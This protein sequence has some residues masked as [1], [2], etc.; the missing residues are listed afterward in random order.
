MKIIKKI[1]T[2]L[3]VSAFSAILTITVFS[4]N[5]NTYNAYISCTK[6]DTQVHKT[7]PFDMKNFYDYGTSLPGDDAYIQAYAS[8]TSNKYH[9]YVTIHYRDY[10]GAGAGTVGGFKTQSEDICGG[11][12][13]L[14][15]YYNQP[16]V[17]FL[18]PTSYAEFSYG[19]ESDFTNGTKTKIV[20]YRL[21]VTYW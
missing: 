19:N 13:N 9:L 16:G 20:T 1:A 5:A 11:G 17:D 8:S 18:Q 21:T 14:N 3:A 7:D 10:V 2:V 4:A 15:S 12:S 6:S